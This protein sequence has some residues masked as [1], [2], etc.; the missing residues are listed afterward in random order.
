[1]GP[2]DHT[3]EWDKQ[4]E[5]ITTVTTNAKPESQAILDQ[6]L[7]VYTFDTSFSR[8]AILQARHDVL[9]DLPENM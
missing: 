9:K 1:M 2:E 7:M 4:V 8:S 5:I 3:P 6:M